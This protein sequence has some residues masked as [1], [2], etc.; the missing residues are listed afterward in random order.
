MDSGPRQRTRFW[1]RLA[2]G[3]TGSASTSRAPHRWK[4]QGRAGRRRS[5]LQGL[6]WAHSCWREPSLEHC[7]GPQPPSR[8][9]TWPHLVTTQLQ[10][11]R[12]GAQ[13]QTWAWGQ[14]PGTAPRSRR[15]QRAF[16]TPL[17]GCP[18]A[19]TKQD[20]LGLVAAPNIYILNLPSAA[21][22]MTTRPP[23][24]KEAEC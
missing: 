16:S 22:S 12:V 3:G 2:S 24:N 4:A 6:Q 13:R 1:R 8:H 18:S 14:Q 19:D 23:S 21:V 7:L 15:G 11:A 20:W 5:E 10:A 17:P 9:S